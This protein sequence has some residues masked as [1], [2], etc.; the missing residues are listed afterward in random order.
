MKVTGLTTSL[1]ENSIEEIKLFLEMTFGYRTNSNLS[2][3]QF[4]TIAKELQ[5]NRVREDEDRF[6]VF[7]HLAG[8]VSLS[9][10][11]LTDSFYSSEAV[12]S[13]AHIKGKKVTDK[14]KKELYYQIRDIIIS[15]C[16]RVFSP[17]ALPEKVSVRKLVAK[18]AEPEVKAPF[19]SGKS[20]NINKIID[21]MIKLDEFELH[22]IKPRHI[23]DRYMS[24]HNES[25]SNGYTYNV[26]TKRKALTK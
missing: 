8:K 24:I 23:M 4:I 18:K 7:Q 13:R 19:M 15:N 9:E 6:L 12:F 11:M 25:I 14:E 3:D 22:E 17:D 26:L 21:E 2:K 16:I 20:L 10:K 5:E 1:K